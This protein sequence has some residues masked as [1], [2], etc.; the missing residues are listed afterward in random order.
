M[1]QL[2]TRMT[3]VAVIILSAPALLLGIKGIAR[4][5]SVIVPFMVVSY[6][7]LALGILVTNAA[8]LPATFALIFRDAFT[9]A[10]ASGGFAGAILIQTIRVGLARGLFSNESGLGSAP[11][12][13]AAARTSC[14][15][16]Q[17]MISMTQTFI[18]TLVICSMTALL[19]LSSGAWTETGADGNGLT[20]LALTTAAFSKCYGSAGMY[21]VSTASIFFAWSTLIGWSYYGEKALEYLSN[22]RG[23]IL[24]RLAYVTAIY[25]GCTM[26]LETVFTISDIF[27]GL[28]AFPNLIAL[29]F[30]S[31]FVIKTTRDFCRS[32]RMRD[33]L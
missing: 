22:G 27:N 30:L 12:V 23:I 25:F 18:D 17:A 11:I 31:P 15:I 19:I 10:A 7:V 4:I 21:L 6:I 26:K 9:P 33:K 8:A 24:Y 20:G 14:P 13:A 3:G 28:M 16:T 32:G 5:T 29:I 2:D 1:L